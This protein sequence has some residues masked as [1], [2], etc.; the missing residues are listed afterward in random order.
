M[1]NI[2]LISTLLATFTYA[3]ESPLISEINE[4]QE[5]SYDEQSLTQSDHLIPGTET[6]T[7]KKS[8]PCT[9]CGKLFKQPCFLKR[10]FRTHT[11]ERPYSCTEC[12]KSFSTNSNLKVHMR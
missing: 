11:G 1:K 9:E 10:H 6:D 7:D 5:Y 2:I 12:K 3:S 8:F 4:S